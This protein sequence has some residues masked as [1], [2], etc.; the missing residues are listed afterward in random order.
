LHQ[1]DLE[2]EG[3]T[4][5]SVKKKAMPRGIEFN[6]EDLLELFD[7]E[8]NWEDVP[9]SQAVSQISQPK[10]AMAQKECQKHFD[11]SI[12]NQSA[13]N[14][15][16]AGAGPLP[17]RNA[18]SVLSSAGAVTIEKEFKEANSDKFPFLDDIRDCNGIRPGEPN[19]DKSTLLI[20]AAQMRALTETQRQYWE[21]KSKNFD[22]IVWFQVGSFFELYAED[23]KLGN[24][25]LGMKIHSKNSAGVP[26]VQLDTWIEKFVAHGYKVIRVDQG[27]F[28][29][30]NFIFFFFRSFSSLF[31]YFSFQERATGRMWIA[32]SPKWCRL[33][34]HWKD[35]TK[36]LRVRFSSC[37]L[38]GQMWRKLILAAN[39]R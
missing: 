15:A 10:E 30:F 37:R 4:G 12:Y 36:C 31:F 38:L 14:T 33:E 2:D 34:P 13:P 22:C 29:T 39:F 3:T 16:V 35:W 5:S 32:P 18:N 1:N 17:P 6:D 27:W 21:V 19:Y 23:A 7:D 26:K 25:L 20:S 28:G 9:S 11:F 8:A 24:E